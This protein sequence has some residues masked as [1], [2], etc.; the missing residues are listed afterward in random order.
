M[1]K[2][3]MIRNKL[4]YSHFSIEVKKFMNKIIIL[5]S[6]LIDNWIAGYCESFIIP[7][8]EES[9]IPRIEYEL[10]L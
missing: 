3:K 8:A 7:I 4:E 9:A 5:E 6:R 2:V 1:L 10:S